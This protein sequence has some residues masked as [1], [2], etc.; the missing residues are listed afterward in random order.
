VVFPV[1]AREGRRYRAG[2]FEGV[3][4][5]LGAPLTYWLRNVLAPPT[6]GGYLNEGLMH[7]VAA[8]ARLMLPLEYKSSHQFDWLLW[9]W[10]D[11]PEEFLDVL[12]VTLQIGNLSEFTITEL[13]KI[14]ELGGSIWRATPQ[15]LQRRVDPVAQKAFGTASAPSDSASQQLTDAWDRAYGRNPNASDAW[16]HSIK[17][18]E[19]SLR[20]IMYSGPNK[21]TLGNIIGDLASQSH[22]WK[23]EI[24][25]QATDHSVDPLI[26]ML[27]LLWPDPNRHGSPTPQ[28][29]ATLEEAR[30]VVQV[31]VTI[32]QWGRDRAL[33]RR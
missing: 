6:A 20:P 14:L 9:L 8:A 13:D 28:P 5:H 25:G 26:Q 29:P 2:P 4:D 27:K 1:T 19:A 16:D 11:E 3:P 33:T 32:V 31:A 17:A 7:Q 22:L 10:S 21:A 18:V 23:L 30:A 15:G 24:R 12:H